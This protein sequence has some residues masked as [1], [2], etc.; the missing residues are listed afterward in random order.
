MPSL[1]ARLKRM[2][3]RDD[4]RGSEGSVPVPLNPVTIR[5]Q[6]INCGVDEGIEEHSYR[7]TPDDD[8][9]PAQRPRSEQRP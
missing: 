4:S 8:K 9:W 1:F 7:G 3:R 2:L 5:T 6:R